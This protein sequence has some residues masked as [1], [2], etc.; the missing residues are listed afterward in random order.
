MGTLCQFEHDDKK[1][2][3]YMIEGKM[4]TI[5]REQGPKVDFVISHLSISRQHARVQL[6]KGILTIEDLGST[7]GTFLNGDRLAKK[8]TI[9]QKHQDALILKFGE[10]PYI[11]RIIADPKPNQFRNEERENRRRTGFEF[12]YGK[13]ISSKPARRSRSRSPRRFKE[14]GLLK[15]DVAPAHLVVDDDDDEDL[16]KEKSPRKFQPAPNKAQLWNKTEKAESFNKWEAASFKSDAKKAKFLKLMG[17]KNVDKVGND[18]AQA[19]KDQKKQ[20]RE[21]EHQFNQ[22][23]YQGRS[24]GGLGM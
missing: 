22:G 24:T 11:F 19:A 10:M 20:Q 9:S 15:P 18:P 14:G 2:E 16:M 4:Y 5:G 7:N 17:A 23:V 3:W 21:L 8:N 13:M 1:Q 12:D 6:S